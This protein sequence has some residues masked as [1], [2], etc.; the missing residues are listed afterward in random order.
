MQLKEIY[1][2]ANE[3]APFA[4]SEEY[5]EKFNGYDNSGIQLDCGEEIDKILFSLDLSK[6][7]I[8]KAQKIGANLIFT[9]HPAIFTPLKCLSKTEGGEILTCAKEHISV[10][11]AHL[12]LDVAEGGIDDSLMYGLKAKHLLKCMHVL[13]KGAYGKLFQIEKTPLSVLKETA[14][15]TFST[16]RIFPLS[17]RR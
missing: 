10:I 7:A 4:L 2:I 9:H 5:C 12:N 3:I 16:E 1:K 17:P 15:K 14:E 6:A 8:K 11:S 13:S